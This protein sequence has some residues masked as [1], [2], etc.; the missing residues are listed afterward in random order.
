MT[1][2]TNASPVTS[3]QRAWVTALVYAT[4][5]TTGIKKPTSACGVITGALRDVRMMDPVKHNKIWN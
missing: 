3:A 4:G 2:P 1:S 5:T